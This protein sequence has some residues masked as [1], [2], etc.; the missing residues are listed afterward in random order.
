MNSVLCNKIFC[1]S[2]EI[3]LE[4]DN[5]R[6]CIQQYNKSKPQKI[7]QERVESEKELKEPDDM[8]M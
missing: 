7:P 8:P 4:K 6:E 1:R 3:T 5:Q 2:F